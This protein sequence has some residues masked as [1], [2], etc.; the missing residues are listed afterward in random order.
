ML[1]PSSPSAA[2]IRADPADETTLFSGPQGEVTVGC[3]VKLDTFLRK[4]LLLRW[5]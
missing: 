2:P 4:R 1:S 5:A 3:L